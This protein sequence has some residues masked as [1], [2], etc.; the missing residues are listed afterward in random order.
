MAVFYVR[1]V[2]W[3]VRSIRELRRVSFG[4][5]KLKQ[6]LEKL[7]QAIQNGQDTRRERFK[8]KKSYFPYDDLRFEPEYRSRL[9]LFQQPAKRP[10]IG[11]S[12]GSTG[13]S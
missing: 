4:Q 5:L 1:L 7:S 2:R 13:L 3:L 8:S 10:V 9:A 6:V 12:A 11:R